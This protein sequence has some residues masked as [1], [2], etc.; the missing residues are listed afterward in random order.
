MANTSNKHK[1]KKLTQW[2]IGALV[3]IIIGSFI[4]SQSDKKIDPATFADVE[5]FALEPRVKG[6]PEAEISLV[7]YADFQCPACAQAHPAVKQVIDT[8]GNQFSFEFRHY[9]LRSIHPNAQLAA[10]AS[11]AAGVQGKFWEMHDLLFE[12]QADWAQSINPKKIFTGY[13]EELGLNT[14]RFAFDLASDEVKARV[15]A[16]A[17]EANVLMLPGTPSF[18]VNGEVSTFQDFMAMLDLAEAEVTNVEV[19]QTGE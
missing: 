18:L 14:D 15:N 16:H 8:Y 2:G 11:E 19:T 1:N 9:P 6:N 5:T 3:V 12:R 4:I 10:E 13:A 17:D 7:E